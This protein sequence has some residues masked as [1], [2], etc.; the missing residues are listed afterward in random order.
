MASWRSKTDYQ[1]DTYRAVYVAKFEEAVYVLDCFQK[2][3]PS[4]K[5]LPKNIQ[6]R[7]RGRYDFV[8]RNRPA[9]P[10]AFPGCPAMHQQQNL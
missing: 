7:L 6:E 10:V 2:R 5:G 9:R 3:S 1:G 8:K 4:G